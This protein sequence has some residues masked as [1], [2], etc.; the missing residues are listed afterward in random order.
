MMVDIGVPNSEDHKLI[1]R[2][3]ILEVTQHVWPEIISITYGQTDN[4]RTHVRANAPMHIADDFKLYAEIDT[5][6]L[7]LAIDDNAFLAKDWQ[8]STSVKEVGSTLATGSVLTL[9][10]R[11]ARD[12]NLSG[13]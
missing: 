5:K 8:L 11:N 10:E 7:Q 13:S 9:F 12:V 6:Q 1:I 2:V 3:I 4:I